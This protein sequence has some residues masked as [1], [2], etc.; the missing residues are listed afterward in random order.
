MYI[1]MLIT[2]VAAKPVELPK[3]TKDIARIET[4]LKRHLAHDSVPASQLAPVIY[5]LAR[6]YNVSQSLIVRVIITESRGR[7]GAYNLKSRDCGIAQ[8]NDRTAGLYGRK[9]ETICNPGNWR[10]NLE[11]GVKILSSTTRPCSYNVGPRYHK[12]LTQCLNYERK[13]ASVK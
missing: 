7:A 6:K 12:K 9:L 5:R 11:L 8:I 3:S 1:L 2:M 10:Q 13:L 4:H